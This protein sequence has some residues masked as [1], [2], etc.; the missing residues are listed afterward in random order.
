VTVIFSV[1]ACTDEKK[2]YEKDLETIKAYIADK[3]I[4]GAETT[5]SGLSYKITQV[6]TG[7]NPVATSDVS[8]YYK[9]YL[10]DGSVFDS[11]LAPKAPIAFNLQQVIAGWTEGIPKIKK[12]GKA[13]LFVP[14]R[15]GYGSKAVATIPA[16]SVLIF[17]VELVDFN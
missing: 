14:S 11:N 3:G 17:E 13:T 12:G 10:T 7:G 8:V 9:G 2:Q 15:L 16:N 6:G 1:S 4:T 5:A